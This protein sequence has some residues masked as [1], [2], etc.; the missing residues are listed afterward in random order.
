MK[1]LIY[2]AKRSEYPWKNLIW[3]KKKI[4][5]QYVS[6]I[7]CKQSSFK[8]TA[9]KQMTQEKNLRDIVNFIV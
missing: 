4:S 1:G 9:I 8:R 2:S 7:Q 3:S 6:T 5:I